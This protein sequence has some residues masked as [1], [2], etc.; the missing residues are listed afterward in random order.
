[1]CAHVWWMECIHTLPYHNPQ[2]QCHFLCNA[3]SALLGKCS[4]VCTHLTRC[5]CVQPVPTHPWPAR[6]PAHSCHVTQCVSV[7]SWG[8]LRCLVIRGTSSSCLHAAPMPR[9]AHRG[10]PGSP[11]AAHSACRSDPHFVLRHAAAAPDGLTANP[12]AEP[13]GNWQVQRVH[14]CKEPVT[15]CFF[16]IVASAGWQFVFSISERGAPCR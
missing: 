7:V 16:L 15:S 11:S 9:L 10:P 3:C 2:L 14:G 13:A 5:A 6:R 8:L 4:P 1:M 12:R